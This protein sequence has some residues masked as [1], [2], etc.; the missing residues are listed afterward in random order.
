ML[1]LLHYSLEGTG[2]LES[3]M[4][5]GLAEYDGYF[6]TTEWNRTEAIHRLFGRS[7][8]R[9]LPSAIYCCRTLGGGNPAMATTDVYYGGA[10]VMMFL[11]EHFGEGLHADLFT[12][13]MGGFDAGTRDYRR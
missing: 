9:D 7:E 3:W 4:R 13:P 11:A 1:N 5:E 8:E 10:I 12:G 6:H 2:R